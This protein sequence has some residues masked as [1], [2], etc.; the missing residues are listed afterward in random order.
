MRLL[1]KQTYQTQRKYCSSKYFCDR[2]IALCQYLARGQKM[3][4]RHWYKQRNKLTSRSLYQPSQ[5]DRKKNSELFIDYFR[6]PN[7][8][9][10]IF[11]VKSVNYPAYGNRR[12][13][14][15]K[16]DIT[17][18]KDKVKL[19]LDTVYLSEL[20]D[21]SSH[22]SACISKENAMQYFSRKICLYLWDIPAGWYQRGFRCYRWAVIWH[23]SSAIIA[24]INTLIEATCMRNCSQSLLLVHSLPTKPH[25]CW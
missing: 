21:N 19:K 24:M 1:A 15:H 12:Y 14:V 25:A 6:L 23:K 8:F 5:P 11:C 3:K 17:V 7:L 10:T 16:K 9:L 13:L 20:W 22:I 2:P 4:L 18:A